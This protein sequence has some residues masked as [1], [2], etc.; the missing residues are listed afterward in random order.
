MADKIIEVDVGSS[1]LKCPMGFYAEMG[2]RA[3][4][5]CGQA[6]TDDIDYSSPSPTWCPLRTGR[7]IIQA[8][9]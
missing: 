2:D 7:V 4:V 9:K 6:P 5:L 8:K 3:T 1:C